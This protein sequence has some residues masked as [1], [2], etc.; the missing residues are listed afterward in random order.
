VTTI[1]PGPE[2]LA[3]ARGEDLNLGLWQR[4]RRYSLRELE[5]FVLRLPGRVVELLKISAPDAV[6]LMD[7]IATMERDLMLPI[8]AAGIALLLYS[9]YFKRSWV[10]V[11][12]LGTLEITVEATQY[13]L[14][15]YIAA[16]V[17]V[18]GL[19]LAMNRVPL[20]LV[21]WAV[22]A[23]SLVDGIFLS[24]LVVVTGGYDSILYWLFLGLIIRGAV[25][26]PRA[27][28]QLLL[29]LTLTVCYVMAGAANISLDQTLQQESQAIAA[30]QTPPRHPHSSNGPPARAASSRLPPESVP[31]A[32]G[33]TGQ[34]A[35]AESRPSTPPRAPVEVDEASW[36]SSRFATPSDNPTQTLTLR[37][38]LLLLMT[39]CCYGVQVLMERQRRA[40]EEERE[41]AMRE[42]QLRS[43]GR[44]AAEFTHQIKNPLAIINNAAFSLQ[45]AVKQGK[46]ISPEQIRIIQEEVEHSDRIITQI[47]GYAQLSEGHVERL[48]LIDELDHAISQV[49]PPA[50]G[51]PVRLHRQ[52][53]GDY[54]PLFMQR[55]HLSDA[56]MNLLQNAREA[57]GETGGNVFVSA[58][59]HSDYSIEITIRDDGPGIPSDKQE[60]I[61]EAYYTTKE[62]GTGLGLATVKHNVDLYGG[63]VRVESVLGKGARFT[64]VFPAR[65]LIKLARQR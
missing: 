17:V 26:V 33:E 18:A 51:Y 9:F 20:L 10:G 53:A 30:L 23:M 15:L 25:S 45:R 35:L 58:Q 11:K 54:P 57:L 41:F 5:E 48:S 21:Q 63:T 50:A 28:S 34:T 42:G 60:K 29:N 49:F 47:M 24:A 52:Y 2:G 16:N 39:V 31:A 40:V 1:P 36:E 65:A 59:C 4:L 46:A 12:E 32:G 56:L 61:W 6:K 7:R 55:R 8:K 64:L 14:W 3:G 37:L 38:A 44:V 13:F 27:T 62:K 22:F 19:L 43:A